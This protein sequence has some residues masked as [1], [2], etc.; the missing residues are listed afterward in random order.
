MIVKH[1]ILKTF[2]SLL[3]LLLIVAAAGCTT[4][5]ES[6]RQSLIS[7]EAPQAAADILRIGVAPK[8]PPLIFERNGTIT[9]LEAELGRMLAEE[10]GRKPV[11]VKMEFTQLIP[12]LMND[13]IDIIMS[14]MTVTDQRRVRVAFTNPYLQLGQLALV[15]NEDI[16]TY[17][18]VGIIVGKARIGVVKG[19]AGDIFVER[20]CRKAEKVSFTSPEKA[21]SAL[22]QKRI[23]VFINDAPVIWWLASEHEADGLTYQRAPLTREEIAWGLLPENTELINDANSILERWQENGTLERV[24]RRWLPN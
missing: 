24:S 22:I 1:I 21:A 23:D 13:H 18:N 10:L 14:D 19:S 11:F 8:F 6:L 17:D 20:N 3:P 16:R 4:Q 2:R 7:L 5:P 12:S 9:G 15:R